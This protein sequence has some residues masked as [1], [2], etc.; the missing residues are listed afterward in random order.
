MPLTLRVPHARFLSVG[1]LVF[2]V[3]PSKSR[4]AFHR[5]DE[6]SAV[7]ALTSARRFRG[8]A[9]SD[10]QPMTY[11][12]NENI[13]QNPLK[14]ALNGPLRQACTWLIHKRTE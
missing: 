14:F 9:T 13:P 7:I 5:D 8:R 3:I 4:C 6:E 2:G 12:P 11:G 10:T 1:L